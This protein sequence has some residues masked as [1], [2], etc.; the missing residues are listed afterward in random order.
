MHDDARS[1]AFCA[2]DQERSPNLFDAFADRA[3][4]EPFS[5][6]RLRIEASSIIAQGECDLLLCPFQVQTYAAGPAVTRHIGEGFL[7]QSPERLFD[8]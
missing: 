3:Q 4:S 7:G 8:R 6:Y 5:L 1:C 2:L